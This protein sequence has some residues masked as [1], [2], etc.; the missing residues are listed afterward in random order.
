MRIQV[1]TYFSSWKDVTYEQAKNCIKNF[2]SGIS[3]KSEQEKID[4]INTK[5]LKGITVNE[6]LKYEEQ[7][8]MIFKRNLIL[9]KME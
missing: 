7:Q 4:Y 3:T 1:K 9:W 6:V 8:D 2:M 5:K